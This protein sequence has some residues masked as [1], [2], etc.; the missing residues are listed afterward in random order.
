MI[1]KALATKPD[2]GAIVDSL[3]WA[4]YRLG[5][6]DQSVQQLE[7]ATELDPADAEINNHLGDAYWR[8]GRHIEAAFQWRRVLTL[9]PDAKLKAEVEAK[10]KNAG[11]VDEKP[12]SS[13]IAS[14]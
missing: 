6:Y 14:G 3:G 8:V 11:P 2:S 10:L 1:E 9:Q 4:Y 13:S 12:K 7:R 5:D